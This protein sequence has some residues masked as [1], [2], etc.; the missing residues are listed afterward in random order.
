[1]DSFA[2]DENDFQESSPAVEIDECLITHLR[3]VGGVFQRQ[4]WVLGIHDRAT[5]ETRLFV[6]GSDRTAA[7]ILPIIN[8]NVDPGDAPEPT[9]VYTDGASFYGKLTNMGYDHRVVVHD[10]GFGFGTETTNH[11]ES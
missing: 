4:C 10:Q 9:R 11:I 1:M 5:K 3:G 7:S 6:V 8:S 2:E